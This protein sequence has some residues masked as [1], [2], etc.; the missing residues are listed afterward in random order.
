MKNLLLVSAS[1]VLLSLSANN[2]GAQDAHKYCGSTEALEKLLKARPEL[3]GQIQHEDEKLE[4]HSQQYA[5]QRNTRG[6]VYTI[7]VVFHI[8]HDYGVENI[9]DAQ[10]YDAVRILNED[11][12]KL[13]SDTSMVIDEFKDVIGNAEIRF[14][15]AQKDPNGNCTNGIVRKASAETYKGVNG[16]DEN[17]NYST[18]TSDVSR[19]PRE[20]YLNVWVVSKILS[21]AAGYTYKPGSVSNNSDM[22]GIMIL[23]NYI[24]SIGTGTAGRSRA[25]THE[26]GHWLNLSHTW[27]NTNDP[28]VSS[29]CSSDDNISDTPNTIGW[30]SCNLSGTTCS[31][32]DNVQNYM[33]YSY[34]S[35]MFTNG[36]ATKM[37]A[38]ITSSTAKRSSLTTTTNLSNTGTS[39][40]ANIL[41]KADFYADET[42]ICEGQTVTFEDYSYNNPVSWNWSFQGASVTS[43]SDQNPSVTYNTAGTYDVS[44]TIGDGQTNKS[45]TK[46]GYII[47][48]PENGKITPIEESFENVSSFPNEDWI[49]ENQDAGVTWLVTS[50]AA[51]TGLKSI[52]L[53][54]TTNTADQK[55]AI[56]SK[57]IDV[58]GLS[59][60]H[61]SF[62]VAFAMKSSGN[63]DALKVYVSNTC[64]QS[65]SMR[66]NR[67]GSTLANG[68]TQTSAFTPTASQWQDITITNI[69][70]SYLVS[71]FRL[72]FEFTSGGGNNIYIDD[73]NIY[74]PVTGV[75]AEANSAFNFNISPNPMNENSIIK[76][77]LPSGED[78]RLSVIDLV[79]KEVAVIA[80][81]KLAAG[82]HTFNLS[83]DN[84]SRGVYFINLEVNGRSYIKKLVVD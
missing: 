15:L 23:H 60:V 66:L 35:R 84:L 18:S 7:P 82:E 52:K 42:V 64:G 49:V 46:S 57:T 41:C 32:L 11:F 21:G 68:I 33:D 70:S 1:A 28:G 10:V 16:T 27:G 55:D 65:W 51:K 24:G 25:L 34:C 3:A 43:S 74:D 69:P 81:Q 48:L 76:F 53:N 61:V 45:T 19:W 75:Q 59:A 80:T 31:T 58:S 62:K 17:G 13:N 36:Q 8:I 78:V 83:G 44:L 20:K 38:A 77:D 12:Q 5:A 2:L 22:D 63:D 14:K 67:S 40:G 26:I 54:N 56:L 72:K 30:T 9:S 47:V 79:G 73:I 4:L 71:D 39:N 50:S 6:T 29:N 37:R